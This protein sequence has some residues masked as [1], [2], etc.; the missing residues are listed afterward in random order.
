MGIAPAV[1]GKTAKQH[2]TLK[3]LSDCVRDNKAG[4]EGY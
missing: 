1:I 2:I 4:L 3:T